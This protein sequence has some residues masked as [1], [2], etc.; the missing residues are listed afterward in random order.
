MSSLEER[1]L[2]NVLEE[3]KT[4]LEIRKKLEKHVAKGHVC[5]PGWIDNLL[6]TGV[7]ELQQEVDTPSPTKQQLENSSKMLDIQSALIERK[8]TTMADEVTFDYE[9]LHLLCDNNASL[10]RVWTV[11]NDMTKIFPDLRIVPRD[12]TH[13]LCSEDGTKILLQSTIGSYINIPLY[14]QLRWTDDFIGLYDFLVD[15]S[16]DTGIE[17]QVLSR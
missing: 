13:F 16:G 5:T 9:D 15:E 2:G 17:R 1:T 11:Q 7:Q 6:Q 14:L 4:I 10:L 3:L 8:L 12:V